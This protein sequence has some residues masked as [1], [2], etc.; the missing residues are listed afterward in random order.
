MR[1]G[2]MRQLEEEVQSLRGFNARTNALSQCSRD[3]WAPERSARPGPSRLT[4]S[5][6]VPVGNGRENRMAFLF[7][8]VLEDGTPADPPMLDVAVPN[9]S[10]GDTIPLG[11]DR[12]LRVIDVLPAKGD[13]DEPVLVVIEDE[14]FR[15]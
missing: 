9:W 11:R 2:L 15:F 14:P 7:K 5:R 12:M 10:A 6:S 1:S 4:A 13:D 8:L 3:S